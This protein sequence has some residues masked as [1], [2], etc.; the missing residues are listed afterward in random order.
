MPPT[1]RWRASSRAP[2]WAICRSGCRASSPNTAPGCAATA[3]ARRASATCSFSATHPLPPLGGSERDIA[4]SSAGACVPS[5][6]ASLCVRQV[7]NYRQFAEARAAQLGR[8]FEELTDPH[9]SDIVSGAGAGSVH[10][11]FARR[12]TVAISDIRNI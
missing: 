9:R 2:S 10:L 12:V 3:H 7:S 5:H 11:K 4:A 1:C 6:K 8:S